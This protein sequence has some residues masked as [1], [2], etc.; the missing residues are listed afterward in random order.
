MGNHQGCYKLWGKE[1]I[2][3]QEESR[4]PLSLLQQVMDSIVTHMVQGLIR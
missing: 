4:T 3:K 1:P 2:T